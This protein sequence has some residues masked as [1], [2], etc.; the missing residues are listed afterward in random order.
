MG[1]GFKTLYKRFTRVSVSDVAGWKFEFEVGE[2]AIPLTDDFSVFS[3]DWLGAVTPKW[4]KELSPPGQEFS[5]RFVASGVT[6]DTREIPLSDDLERSFLGE[7]TAMAILAIQVRF[8]HC[9]RLI[10]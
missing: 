1:F 10:F 8:P 7:P 3:R 5:S 9:S 6:H 2:E 4:K